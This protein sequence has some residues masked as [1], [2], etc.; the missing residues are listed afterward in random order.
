MLNIDT[1]VDDVSASTLTGALI[2]GVSLASSPV[3]RKSSKTPRSILLLSG[4]LDADVCILLNVLNLRSL[5]VPAHGILCNVTHVGVIL[6]LLNL[7]ILETSSE[8]AEALGVG[9]VSV[10]LDGRDGGADGSSPDAALHLD[11]VLAIDKLDAART[12]DRSRLSPAG[13]SGQRKGEKGEKSGGSH[14]DN[15]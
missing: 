7:I 10:G 15:E 5:L 1:G 6:E 12:K 9:V 8:T 11:D 3:A 4:R 2:V 13:G 14:L